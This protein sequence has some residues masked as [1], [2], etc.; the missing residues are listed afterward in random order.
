MK[1][2]LFF[3][4]KKSPYLYKIPKNPYWLKKSNKNTI[5]G[6][7][8]IFFS[9]WRKNNKGCGLRC[10]RP[11]Q[12]DKKRQSFLKNTH[13]NLCFFN[14]KR[15]K[16]LFGIKNQHHI[17]N[18][19]L[20]APISLRCRTVNKSAKN[21][22]FLKKSHKRKKKLRKKF[23]INALN[24]L[25]YYKYCC[26]CCKIRFFVC[27]SVFSYIKR[28]TKNPQ[29]CNI[30]G[31]A[32]NP[33]VYH[34]YCCKLCKIIFVVFKSDFSCIKKE[35]SK[36]GNIGSINCKYIKKG[37]EG[38]N[39]FFCFFIPPKKIVHIC[40]LIVDPLNKNKKIIKVRSR[41][42]HIL[43]TLKSLVFVTK[44]FP[45]KIYIHQSD[46]KPRQDI[47]ENPKNTLKSDL[48]PR[49]D[50]PRKKLPQTD[51]RP[52]QEQEKT[53]FF[54]EKRGGWKVNTK[55]NFKN[56]KSDLNTRII[57]HRLSTKFRQNFAVFGEIFVLTPP[58]CRELI[59]L[60]KKT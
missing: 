18:L 6:R 12:Q 20:K 10:R 5:G 51:L 23:D 46:L 45:E 22:H 7:C 26:E 2:F 43:S 28:I 57:Q 14:R 29:F 36:K 40:C 59:Y 50:I 25:T 49:Q 21:P 1:I 42:P 32:L 31:K 58:K 4:E 15:L 27:S 16:L 41:L 13:K 55:I 48:K 54:K 39:Y 17:K 53:Y 33:P 35:Q 11:N 44:K 19:K 3:R 38:V 56:N 34:K 37:R 8:L 30:E 9:Y 52:R 60:Q 47:P 24:L